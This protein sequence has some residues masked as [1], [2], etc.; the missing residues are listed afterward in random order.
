MGTFWYFSL[1]M[2]H[3]RILKASRGRQLRV[4]VQVRADSYCLDLNNAAFASLLGF[5][6]L[7]QAFLFKID[8]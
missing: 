1:L 7:K 4:G 6:S 5:N 3:V 2:H 8:N